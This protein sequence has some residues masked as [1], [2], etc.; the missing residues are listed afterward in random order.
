MWR[1]L[2]TALLLAGCAQL[3]PSPQDIQAKRFAPVPDK[4]VI[5]IVRTPLDSLQASGL[6]LGDR[7]QI[8]T[9]PGTYYRWEV[10]P[11]VHRIAGYASANESVTLTTAAGRVYFL[12]HTVI[13]SGQSG[14]QSTSLRQIDE[15]DGHALVTRA[16]LL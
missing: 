13:G 12:E 7:A 1:I 2:L 15:R 10:T 11:G 16:Q 14:P 4:A 5:Y 8:T 6:W 9:L 3:P